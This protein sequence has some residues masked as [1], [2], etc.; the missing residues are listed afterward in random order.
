MVQ[1]KWVKELINPAPKLV[2]RSLDMYAVPLG[3]NEAN[4]FGVATYGLGQWSYTYRGHQV[5][6]HTGG[7][8]GASSLLYTLPQAGL[9]LM[10]A[11]NDVTFAKEVYDII[12]YRLVDELLGENPIIDWEGRF[13]RDEFGAQKAIGARPPINPRPAK[14]IEGE[15]DHPGYGS[16][17]LNAINQQKHNGI[18]AA[19]VD[20]LASSDF[21]L[22]TSSVWLSHW[23]KP[24]A[25]YVAISHFDG[26]LFNWTILGVYNR[27]DPGLARREVAVVHNAGP[28]VINEKGMGM[29][30]NWYDAGPTVDERPLVVNEN[31]VQEAAEVWFSRLDRDT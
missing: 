6:G 3:H 15:Y 26:P 18:P 2:N 21:K 29:F 1:V 9:G 30:G 25:N 12:A 23:N 8:P 19:V 20:A 13:M 28:A 22:N 7:L 4:E 17:R 5:Y 16:F 14:D 24:F 11:V 10:I 27:S 31:Q